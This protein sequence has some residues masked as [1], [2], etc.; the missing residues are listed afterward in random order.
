M[1]N[2]NYDLKKR[3]VRMISSEEAWVKTKSGGVKLNP[4]YRFVGK[5]DMQMPNMIVTASDRK[6]FSYVDDVCK[7]PAASKRQLI[8]HFYDEEGKRTCRRVAYLVDTKKCKG[9]KEVMTK[10]MIPINASMFYNMFYISF[11]F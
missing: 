6:K 5:V 4:M 7:L 10:K 8:R 11:F 9:A 3:G 2:V 1:S